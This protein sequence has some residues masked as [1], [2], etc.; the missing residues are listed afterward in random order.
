M[1]SSIPDVLLI[2]SMDKLK[3]WVHELENL[4]VLSALVAIG[5]A[6]GRDRGNIQEELQGNG[7]IIDTLVHSKAFVADNV[8]LGVGTQVL[9][10]S[11]IVTNTFIGNSSMDKYW[12]W[13]RGGGLVPLSQKISQITP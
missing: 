5:G 2:G 13:L 1:N 11:S 4:K 10:M 7:I 9:A 12:K 3:G 6:R 8:K